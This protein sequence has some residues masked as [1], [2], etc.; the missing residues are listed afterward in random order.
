MAAISPEVTSKLEKIL[1]TML[2]SQ[3]SNLGY[4]SATSQSAYYPSKEIVTHE[5]I[6]AV[7]RFMKARNI[8]PEN[9]RLFKAPRNITFGPEDFDVFEIL[10]AS[11]ELDDEPQQLADIEIGTDRRAKIFLRRGD[12]SAELTK[13]CANLTKASSYAANDTQKLALAQLIQSFRTGDY[14]AFNASQRTWVQDKGSRVEHCMGFLF[15]YRDP[16]GMRAEWQAFA[17]IADSKE[18]KKMSQLVEKST[19]IIRTLPWAVAGENN[20]KG[21]FEPSELDVP[22][23]AVIDG[24]STKFTSDIGQGML[25]IS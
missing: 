23:F 11:A 13:I 9:T 19:E 16:Y 25:T 7:T 1:D 21:P 24:P 4:P 17:G 2:M 3:P 18:T 14:Q 5:E 10:Q 6:E 12:H 20:G 15:G 22:D 8:A